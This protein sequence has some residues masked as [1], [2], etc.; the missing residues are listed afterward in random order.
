MVP[1]GSAGWAPVYDSSRVLTFQE[2][3][4]GTGWQ[5]YTFPM[6]YPSTWVIVGAILS[7]T[8]GTA[9]TPGIYDGPQDVGQAARGYQLPISGMTG[10]YPAIYDGNTST[11]Y[12]DALA[13]STSA[14]ITAIH[15]LGTASLVL[16]GFVATVTVAGAGSYVLE[17]SNDGATWTTPSGCSG[18]LSSGTNSL[19]NGFASSISAR[20]WRLSVQQSGAAPWQVKLAEFNVYS[21]GGI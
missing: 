8:A 17:W 15:D 1:V 2:N 5:Q 20:W 19:S 7:M 10:T 4:S 12:G 6:S 16:T 11:Y 3:T 9:I 13:Q 18:A 14:A 21:G